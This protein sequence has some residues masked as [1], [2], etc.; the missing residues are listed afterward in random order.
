M[1]LQSKLGLAG[2]FLGSVVSAGCGSSSSPTEPPPKAIPVVN[3]T[4]DNP[5]VPIEEEYKHMEKLKKGNPI[6]K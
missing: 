5:N 6:T 4:P 1:S 3:P 2:F